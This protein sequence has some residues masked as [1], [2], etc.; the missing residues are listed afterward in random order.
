LYNL[1]NGKSELWQGAEVK[2]ESKT[3][4]RLTMSTKDMLG[5]VVRKIV[6]LPAE[7]L[8]AILDFFGKLSSEAGQEWFTE[9]KK[10]LRKEQSWTGVVVEK[11]LQL[12]SGGEALT[13]DALN[14]KDDLLAKDG[15]FAWIDPDFEN[16]GAD[17]S[18]QP[19][20]ETKVEVYEMVKNATFSQM[21]G[22]LSPDLQKVCFSSRAQV[23]EFVKKHR[24]WLRKDGY[25]TFFLYKSNDNYFVADVHVI[26][27]G[28][29]A[30]VYRPGHD[31]VWDG[32]YRLRVVVP[33]L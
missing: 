32:V 24:K 16:Y 30:V 29:N 28:L 22:S 33:Q 2:D 8:G 26:S 31:Y 7:M 23:K 3:K 14:G 1:Y 27:A 21:F 6:E 4:R 19:T 15:T 18:C 10:F 17:E 5:A 20:P 9:F 12:I 13:I 25:A 11:I